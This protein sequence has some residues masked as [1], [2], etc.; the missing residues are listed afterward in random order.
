[1]A[2]DPD[3]TARCH[4]A[5]LPRPDGDHAPRRPGRRIRVSRDTAHGRYQSQGERR[6]NRR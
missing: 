6:I 5:T 2:L 3:D 4:L 1:V